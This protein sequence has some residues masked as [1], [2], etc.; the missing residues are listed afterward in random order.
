MQE[1]PMLGIEAPSGETFGQ[2]LAC[3]TLAV[4]WVFVQVVFA[5]YYAH[6]FYGPNAQS[7]NPQ[8]VFPNNPLP[9][10]L[11]FIR[12]AF[13]I[14]MRIRAPRVQ[15]TSKKMRRVVLAHSMISFVFNVSIFVLAVA[16]VVQRWLGGA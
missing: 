13:G 5:L 10:Y 2:L 12:F 16:I 7:S 6:Q 11:D 4:S 9:D 14:G 1:D 15:V 3:G 8:F